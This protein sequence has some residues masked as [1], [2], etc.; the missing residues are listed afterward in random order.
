MAIVPMTD[1]VSG[2][3]ALSAE[4]NKLI[5][6]IQ[7]LDARLGAVVSG[8]PA[9]TRLTSLETLTGGGTSGNAALDTRVGS[10]ES[11]TTNTATN[12][13]HGNVRL[14]DRLGTG[15]GTGTNVTTGS[16]TSQLTDVRSRLTVVEGLAGS[17]PIAQLR[18]TGTAQ[19]NFAS[20][21][22]IPVN[23]NTEDMDTHNGHSTSTNTSRW[24]CPSGWAGWYEVFGGLVFD[25]V[26]TTGGRVAAIRVNGA[27]INGGWG[28]ALP[29]SV[30]QGAMTRNLLVQLAVGDYIE[31]CGR[32]AGGG[33]VAL[34]LTNYN[35]PTL[36]I[37]FIKA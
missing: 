30:G 33:T 32:W 2:G 31:L 25:S 4:Y 15:V 26:S 35:Q 11:L 28:P 29:G 36:Y 13:G 14:S 27:D 20:G 34:D 22:V 5:D 24:V 17:G 23:F 19:S 1:A 6:N 12:G 10:L 16:A 3:I 8:N 21:S 37:K 18:Q 7:D 9:H